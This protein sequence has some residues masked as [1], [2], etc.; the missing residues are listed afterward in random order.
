M[1]IDYQVLPNQ[2]DQLI[3]KLR[4]GDMHA[5]SSIYHQ[6]WQELYGIA[7]R[8]LK[9][10]NLAEDVLHDVF[11][12]LWERRKKLYIESSLRGYLMVCVRNRCLKTLRQYKKVEELPSELHITDSSQE[13]QL[14]RNEL[15]ERLYHLLE[16]VPR[17]SKEVFVLSRE[18]Q[19]SYKEIAS[20]TNLSIKSV[21]YH[22]SK[23]LMKLRSAISA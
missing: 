6:Y 18:E 4:A 5:F 19:L 16:R 22:I 10:Q 20:R 15:Q 2:S 3:T 11:A 23:V 1:D 7:H 13:S 17:K 12:D 21:E 14:Y 9:E 8:L